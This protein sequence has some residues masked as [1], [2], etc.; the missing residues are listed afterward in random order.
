M[1]NWIDVF[2]L[3]LTLSIASAVVL[4]LVYIGKATSQ[5][6]EATKASLKNRGVN[7]SKD[8]VSIKTNKRWDRGDYLDATQRG[9]VKAY[10][11]STFGSGLGAGVRSHSASSIRS[12]QSSEG[13]DRHG[14]ASGGESRVFS[15]KTPSG[16]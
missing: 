9:F 13:R 4:G 2:S 12:E 3:V 6:A 14:T 8:G 5:A 15:L 7:L 11:N 10:N 1:A 16:R